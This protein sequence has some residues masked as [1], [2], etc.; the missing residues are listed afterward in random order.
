MNDK[1]LTN[2]KTRQIRKHSSVKPLDKG[3]LEYI[4]GVYERLSKMS[5]KD[6]DD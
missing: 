1:I 2:K 5:E 6:L 4:E 3:Y